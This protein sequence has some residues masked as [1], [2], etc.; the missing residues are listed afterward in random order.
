MS[1][2]FFLKKVYIHLKHMK[3]YD[4]LQLSSRI[5]NLMVFFVGSCWC[6]IFLGFRD[7]V[8]KG[9]LLTGIYLGYRH[10]KTL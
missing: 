1:F 2:M 3:I 8:E 4:I 5:V 7:S 6:L 10:K 9:F